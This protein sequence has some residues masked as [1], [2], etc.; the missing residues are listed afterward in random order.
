MVILDE[1]PF[2]MV[3]GEGF[4]A[5]SQVLEPRFVVPSR[6]TVARDC[7]KL[8]VEEKKALKKLLKSQRNHKG[9][10]IGR[11]IEECLVEWNIEDI[12]TLTVDNASSNDLTIDYLKRNSKWK[13]SI[14][15]NRFL[16]VRC[17][18]HIV[19]LICER[20]LE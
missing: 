13:R 4:R 15:D 3:E 18:A 16:H 19:N 12:L 11:V 5:Y 14:L 20:W 2:K 6:I 17:C 10:T 9:A 1:L 7:M 8:Y